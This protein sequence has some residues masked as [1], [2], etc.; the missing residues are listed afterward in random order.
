MASL[1]IRNLDDRLKELLRV[2][3][4]GHGRSMEEEVR[5]MLRQALETEEP[6]GNLTDLAIA[7]FGQKGGI[8]LEAHPPVPVR[9][10]PRFDT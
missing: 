7:L 6:V 8:D 1:V 9:A 3:A 5:V 2:R 10:A 4:A